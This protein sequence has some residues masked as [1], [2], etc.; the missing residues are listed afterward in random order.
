[1]MCSKKG[2]TR[3][4]SG[5]ESKIDFMGRQKGTKVETNR[6]LRVFGTRGAGD[7]R[8]SD[9][10]PKGKIPSQTKNSRHRYVGGE[11]QHIWTAS[12]SLKSHH[13]NNTWLKK[14][15]QKNIIF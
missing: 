7:H 15:N 13:Q 3:N 10:W 9:L 2:K 1:M 4:I 6:I 8:L 11:S 14:K 12:C 5:C